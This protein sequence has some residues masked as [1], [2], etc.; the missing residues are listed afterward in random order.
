MSAT[1]T[2]AIGTR[3]PDGTIFAG[4]SPDTGRPMYATP[5]DAPLTVTFNE[6]RTY[7]EELHAHSCGDWRIPTRAELNVLFQNRAA[8][9]NFDTSGTAGWH[10]SSSRRDEY[11]TWGQCFSDGNQ[12]NGY[13]GNQSPLRCV[14][15]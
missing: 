8:I 9:G 4:I 5:E 10:W 12:S 13:N 6:A 2:P 1:T 11:N 7:A 15:G 3:M 14:R